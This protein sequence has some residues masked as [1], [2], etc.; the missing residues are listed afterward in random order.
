MGYSERT[1]AEPCFLRKMY[2]KFQKRRFK[3]AIQKLNKIRVFKKEQF[4]NQH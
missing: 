4:I 2:S 1:A 3:K